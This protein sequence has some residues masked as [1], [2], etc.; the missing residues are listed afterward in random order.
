MYTMSNVYNILIII[1][2]SNVLYSSLRCS[3]MV[4]VHTLSTMPHLQCIGTLLRGVGANLV[5][6]SIPQP[7]QSWTLWGEKSGLNHLRPLL[8][9]GRC[10]YWP[11]WLLRQ[12]SGLELMGSLLLTTCLSLLIN[13]EV[14][15]GRNQSEMFLVSIIEG[16]GV[17]RLC[18]SLGVGVAWGYGPSTI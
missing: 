16:C 7:L 5:G 13:G 6:D 12:H 2:M 10:S 11:S 15:W 3:G 14:I 9:E 8:I 4:Q 1:M 17:L 18:P